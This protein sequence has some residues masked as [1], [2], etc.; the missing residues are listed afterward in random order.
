MNKDDWLLLA[1]VVPVSFAYTCI[2][3][4]AVAA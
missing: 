3:L 1:V 4:A 2:L